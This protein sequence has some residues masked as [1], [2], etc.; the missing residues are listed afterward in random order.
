VS[1]PLEVGRDGELVGGERQGQ[2]RYPGDEGL[3]GRVVAGVRHR[4]RGVAQ[5]A[6][7]GQVRAHAPVGRERAEAVGRRQPRGDGRARAEP[8]DPL[9]DRGEHVAALRQEGPEGDVDQRP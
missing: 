3:A 8:A 7:L 2:H 4:R 1:L 6:D 9:G 5:Q